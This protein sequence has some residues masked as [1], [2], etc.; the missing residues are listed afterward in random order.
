MIAVLNQFRIK[1]IS[2]LKEILI[3]IIT[4]SSFMQVMTNAQAMQEAL[5]TSTA[6][7]TLRNCSA[8]FLEMQ[9]SGCQATKTLETLLSP[10]LDLLLPQRWFAGCTVCV[11]YPCLVH[12]VYCSLA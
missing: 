6:T 8:R 5:R 10:T 12:R 11:L 2:L 1:I 3:K 4:L 7:L 9:A